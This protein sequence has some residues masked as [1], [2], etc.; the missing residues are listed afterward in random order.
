MVPVLPAVGRGLRLLLHHTDDSEGGVVDKQGLADRLLLAEDV[1]GKLVSKEHDATLL[2]LVAGVDEATPRPRVVL[3][4]VAVDPARTGDLTVDGLAS[5]GHIGPAVAH[6]SPD[7][8][9]GEPLTK[10]C[11]VVDPR[12]ERAPF[13][14]ALPDLR[15]LS[16]PVDC[17]VLA[18]RARV[19]GQLALQSLAEGEQHQD[20]HGPPG[21]GS[22]RRRG[23]LL[24]EARRA[25]KEV[26]DDRQ[27]PLAHSFIAT[28]GSRRDASRAGKY[29]A[30]SPVTPRTRAVSAATGSEISGSPT[31]FVTPNFGNSAQTFQE[32]ANPTAPPMA[33]MRTVSNRSCR[34]IHSC[35]APS[36]ILIPISFVRSSTTTFMMLETPIPPTTRVKQPT[37]PRN[38]RKE[39]KKMSRNLNC[40]AVSQTERAS[41]SFGSNRSCR[42]RTARTFSVTDSDCDAETGWYT[43]LL[44][45]LTPVSARKVEPGM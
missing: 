39:R 41:L 30:R 16:R 32:I 8:A 24:L 19:G 13:R 38:R 7:F 26:E 31:S 9:L 33:V 22:D 4:R 27:V 43:K 36:A 3:A 12:A 23:E 34:M 15:G 40:S 20:R 2:L 29:P 1:L 28:T 11:N 37:I 35:R 25:R 18:H 45:Y 42:A 5:V 10:G 14:Q 6:L 44:T 17:E 21:D